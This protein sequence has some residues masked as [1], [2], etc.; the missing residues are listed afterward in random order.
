MLRKN[1]IGESSGKY[2]TTN[3]ALPSSAEHREDE[4]ASIAFVNNFT[5]PYFLLLPI[6]WARAENKHIS[7]ETVSNTPLSIQSG[8]RSILRANMIFLFRN[9]D[10][11]PS[12]SRSPDF[13]I[14][15]L[16]R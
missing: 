12:I 2:P 11:M 5:D 14:K 13:G 7:T 6:H 1:N 10:R 3:I 16:L 15:H 9:V 8:R 4:S